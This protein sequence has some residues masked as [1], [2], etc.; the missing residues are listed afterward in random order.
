MYFL[1]LTN[2]VSPSPDAM[3]FLH[4]TDTVLYHLML[5]T[6]YI[7]QIPYCHRLMSN[8]ILHRLMLSTF[9]TYD[10]YG[11]ASPNAT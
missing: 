11:I 9:D 7:E 8:T 4:V 3:Y 10:K 1:H 5:S 2:T 6:F